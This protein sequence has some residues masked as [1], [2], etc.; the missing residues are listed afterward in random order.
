MW[1]WGQIIML[2]MCSFSKWKWN[3]VLFSSKWKWS[4]RLWRRKAKRRK[5]ETEEEAVQEGQVQPRP[6]A[7]YIAG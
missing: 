7:I 3:D 4:E 2:E 1:V 5:K 6:A